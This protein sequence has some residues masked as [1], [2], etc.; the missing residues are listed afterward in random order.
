MHANA[1]LTHEGCRN[2]VGRIAS[3]PPGARVAAEMGGPR[4]RRTGGWRRYQS[5]GD[6]W[7]V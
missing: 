1:R 4:T 6:A 3:G 2:I 5:E 7:L